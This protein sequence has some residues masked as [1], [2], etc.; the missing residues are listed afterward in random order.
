MTTH[1][2]AFDAYGTLFDVHAAIARHRGALGTD[3]EAFSALW[4]AKQLEYSWT[5]TLM[6][7][8]RDFWQLTQDALDFCLARFPGVDPA[9]R[10]P[11]LESY[12]RLDA[13]ADARPTLLR[14]R[15]DGARCALFTNG[16]R[17]MAESAAA[18]AGLAD[19]LEMIV[20]VEAAGRFKT[21]PEVYALV[22]G[23]L[24]L[25][26]AAVTLVSSNRWD[27]A[28]A[29]ACGMPG[30]WVNRTGQPDEYPDLAPVRIITRLDE[31]SC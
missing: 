19:C 24:G 16:T 27:I 18:S 17:A 26:M 12:F 5:R 20:S 23:R 14:L 28:G 3:A 7:R 1:A 29:A 15:A 10:Q 11:L 2:Y 30:I 4:R 6:G 13:F 31:L 22:A 8:T 25:P 9:L 21:V